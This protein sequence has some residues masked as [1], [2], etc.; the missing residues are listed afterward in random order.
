[1]LL[2]ALINDLAVLNAPCVL[3]LDDYHL[4]QTPA[5]HRAVAFLLEHLP[6]Q[7]HVVIAARADPPLP[8]SRQAIK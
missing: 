6:P 8:L 3:V 4:I 7:L 1:V 5:I 2:S